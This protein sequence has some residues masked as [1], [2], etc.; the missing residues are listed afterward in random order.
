MVREWSSF[1]TTMVT[2]PHPRDAVTSTNFRTCKNAHLYHCHMVH[3]GWLYKCAC[4]SVF[5]EFLGNMGQSDYRPED[6]GF[7]IHGAADLRSQ[8]WEF[9]TDKTPLDACRHCLG[10]LAHEQPHHQL[11]AKDVKDARSRP[12]SRKGHLSKTTLTK[13]TLNILAAAPPKY[14]RESSVVAARA[15]FKTSFMLI[16]AS[17]RAPLFS[18]LLPTLVR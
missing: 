12:I 14:S 10:Y 5:G 7:D 4:P 9:L 6:D 2:E 1:R 15:E 13:E 17:R 11:T 16:R 8:L 3:A 18:V